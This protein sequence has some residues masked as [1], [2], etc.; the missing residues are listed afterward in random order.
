M[1]SVEL[2]EER[3]NL[4]K[5]ARAIQVRATEE[6]REVTPE[7]DAEFDRIMDDVDKMKVRI[8][9]LEKLE[10]VESE[11]EATQPRQSEP[12]DP[13]RRDV[14]RAE[15]RGEVSQKRAIDDFR[16]WMQHGEVRAS[17]RLD[18][19]RA[20]QVMAEHRDTI[21][22]TDA[23]GGYLIMP[24]R[25]TNDLVKA[26]DDDVF[27]RRLARVDKVTDAKKLGIRKMTAR[28]ANANW[29]TEVQAVTEDTTM[30]FGRRDLEP[31]LLSKLAKISIRTIAL[32]SDAEGIVR[33]EL[34]YQFSITEEKA[35]LTGTGSSQ[36]LGLFVADAN[37]IT[38][39]RD[40]AITAAASVVITPDLLIAAKYTL[41]QGYLRGPSAA[42]LFHRT[43]V[44]Q[45]RKLRVDGTTGDFVW[46]PGLAPGEPDRI[47]D[48]PFF[49][50]EYV[51]NTY[52]TG[53][54]VGML[55]NFGYY[56]IA[57]VD[58]V[59]LQ[60]LVELY[61]GTNEVGFIGRRWLDGAPVLEEAFV[62][63]KIA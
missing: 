55:G 17:L 60:R 37:G 33:D 48:I 15:D 54:Y 16:Y 5:K 10:G 43:T 1:N 35:Y 61:A 3:A 57:E 8:D 26:I 19:S 62:R 2:R 31:Y 25:L 46:Q 58:Y 45:I 13:D 11:L 9:R 4:A 41:K 24:V 23:K 34:A 53:L 6:N 14:R 36:P 47:L 52:T 30:A 21:I 12:L 38:T 27:I 7:E 56:R 49:M 29:T 22:S 28:M 63:L 32:A 40:V 51:P 44:G 20:D 59:F 50:S 39:A 18:K 42:W